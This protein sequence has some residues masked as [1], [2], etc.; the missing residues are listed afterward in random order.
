ME[1]P[2]FNCQQGA[3]FSLLNTIRLALGPTHPPIQSVSTALSLGEISHSMILAIHLHL[4]LRLRKSA[5]I[6]LLLPD[7]LM[8]WTG[9][10]LPFTYTTHAAKKQPILY[11]S[12]ATRIYCSGT[13]QTEMFMNIVLLS[14]Q[15]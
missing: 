2:G 7:T 13:E 14:S 15:M 3:D 9:T 5:T 6:A 1:N 12:T 4:V 8:V 10:M 11:G